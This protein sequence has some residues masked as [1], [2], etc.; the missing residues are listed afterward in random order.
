MGELRENPITAVRWQKPKVSN[1]V[2][3]R[4]VANPEQAHNLLAAVS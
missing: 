2:D 1:Q 3:P 4:L